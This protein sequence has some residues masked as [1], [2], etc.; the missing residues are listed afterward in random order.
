MDGN[1]V[2]TS[3]VAT[4]IIIPLL[5]VAHIIL[6]AAGCV[7]AFFFVRGL[8]RILGGVGEKVKNRAQK[9]GK[10]VKQEADRQRAQRV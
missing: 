7:A 2:A 10:E 4:V 3:I 8:F 1:G 5:T 9:F 6:A